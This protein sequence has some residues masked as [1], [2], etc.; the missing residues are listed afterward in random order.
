MDADRIAA[1]IPATFVMISG[2]EDKQ[3]SADVHNVGTFDLPQTAGKAGGAC[4]ST[5]LKVIN[6]NPGP[7]SWLQLLQRM[8]GVLRDKGFDQIPQLS[9]S[10]LLDA[11]SRFE[12]VPSDSAPNKKRAILIGIN[13]VG[14]NGELNG[15]H[16][17]VKNIK[18]YLIDSQGFQE[19]DMLILMD[20]GQHNAPTR[21][22]IMDA[23]T[24]IT[25]Y[26]EPGDVV[27][28][29]Y[30]GHG[31]RVEDTSGDEE[32]GFDETLIPV[33]FKSAGQILDD[34]VF[35]KLVKPMKR[36]V[37]V[38]VLMDCC[39][40]GTALDLPYEMNATDT[41][42]HSSDGFNMGMLGNTGAM[43][44]FACLACCDIGYIM[45]FVGDFL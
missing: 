18:R 12:M 25:Q 7:M 37:R 27:F 32:D 40:S 1:G 8:R 22:N 31:G 44:L 15:C 23:F 30:S 21:K 13:Y 39:H 11:N 42:M 9:A 14:Q 26:S 19:A 5:L 24:R 29:H 45:D 43:G 28:V 2:S 36:D 34:E 6:E 3:T 10:R 33:D 4:T 20:D 16:N 17:D 38:T 41:K 35:A